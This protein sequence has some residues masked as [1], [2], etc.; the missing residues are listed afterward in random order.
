MCCIMSTL[1]F[2]L[3]SQNQDYSIYIDALFLV[4]VICW[5]SF[6]ASGLLYITC[7]ECL[8]QGNVL[9]MFMKP[10]AGQTFHGCDLYCSCSMKPNPLCAMVE[11]SFF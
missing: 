7:L 9:G 11:S 8:E 3:I 10:R 4:I 6:S 5:D 1:W 2:Y